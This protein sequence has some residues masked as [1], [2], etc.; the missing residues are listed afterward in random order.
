MGRFSA[1]LV[2]V[3]AML[4]TSCSSHSA[5]AAQTSTKTVT[6]PPPAETAA[7]P[8]VSAPPATTS[9][10]E[11]HSELINVTL[12]AGTVTGGKDTG[13]EMW[14]V[15]T[16]YD[17]TVNSLRQQLPI[18]QPYLGVPWCNQDIN[19]KLGFTE[20]DWMDNSN[21]IQVHIA[22]TG[23]VTIQRKPDDEGRYGCDSP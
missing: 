19:G 23:R 10:E 15:T 1:F 22:Q 13:M 16:P 4:V 11:V 3:T 6:M 8:P 21:I 14:L 12:P 2:L 5:P 17:Y 7:A 9:A 20:W 18:K